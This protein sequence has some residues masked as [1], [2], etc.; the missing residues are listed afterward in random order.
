M[1]RLTKI[2]CQGTDLLIIRLMSK[3][4]A[5]WNEIPY[6]Y[7]NSSWS[8]VFFSSVLFFCTIFSRWFL[9]NIIYFHEKVTE[10]IDNRSNSIHF[11]W[12]HFLF[13]DIV[14]FFISR[15]YTIVVSHNQNVQYSSTFDCGWIRIQSLPG[16]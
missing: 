1:D 9:R 3:F 16:I 14:I 4:S 11:L 13:W 7:S 8:L 10:L 6:C 2:L 12:R 15:R 5:V